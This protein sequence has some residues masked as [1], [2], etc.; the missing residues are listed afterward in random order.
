MV[1]PC[2]DPGHANCKEVHGYMSQR[3]PASD[4]PSNASHQ[5]PQSHPDL[6]PSL[7]RPQSPQHVPTESLRPARPAESPITSPWPPAS[8]DAAPSR[9]PPVLS[10]TAQPH[11]LGMHS[12]LN[13]S[14]DRDGR[15]R[16]EPTS[17]ASR[18]ASPA[19]ATAPTFLSQ[20]DGRPAQEPVLEE[21]SSTSGARIDRPMLTPKSPAARAAS[22][23]A[24]P[25]SSR[26]QRAPTESP[27]TMQGALVPTGPSPSRLGD[28][29]ALPVPTPF[30]RAS[31]P[32]PATIE[33]APARLRGRSSS[34]AATTGVQPSGESPSTSTSSFSYFSPSSPILKHS[35]PPPSRAVAP[36]AH[37]R[38]PISLAPVPSAP[39]LAREGQY[40]MSRGTF[41]ISVPTQE[42]RMLLP[43]EVDVEQASKAANDK[44]KRNAGASARF[45]Q[46][47]KEKEREASQTISSLESRL[48]AVEDE[49]NHYRTERDFFRDFLARQI[50]PAQLPPR[51]PTPS[52]YPFPRTPGFEASAWQDFSRES[53]EPPT[54]NVRRRTGSLPATVA[55]VS[56]PPA[57]LPPQPAPSFLPGP[58]PPMP[59]L[60]HPHVSSIAPSEAPP[61]AAQA[62]LPPPPPPPPPP[63]PPPPPFSSAHDPFRPNIHAR[64][65]NPGP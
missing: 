7:Q 12:I 43:V 6:S 18:P 25:S 38:P 59:P 9:L 24:G 42:G 27:L 30:R 28:F 8:S 19:P 21:G 31:H 62:P 58:P 26:G 29:P 54:R 39:V 15:P 1:Y 13:P 16:V 44:R 48:R 10:A 37:T 4:P 2:T 34:R 61:F 53:S 32:H 49:R 52:V 57:M 47:R 46:R 11:P 41:G 33:S 63:H 51:P 50:G 45:R 14:H 5:H 3:T 17:V 60:Q 40:E 22:F 20:S 55:S 35:G 64:S 23:A 56:V 65:W 36:M